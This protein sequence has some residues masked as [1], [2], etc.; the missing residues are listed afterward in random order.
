MNCKF[1]STDLKSGIK[2]TILLATKIT[3]IN[4]EG[5]NESYPI[6]FIE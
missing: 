3:L 4:Q 1:T 2:H 5:F 6:F